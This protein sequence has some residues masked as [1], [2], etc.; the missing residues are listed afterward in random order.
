M[1]WLSRINSPACEMVSLDLGYALQLEI[2]G[3]LRRMSSISAVYAICCPAGI[4]R[5]TTAPLCECNS[6]TSQ[7]PHGKTLRTA[8]GNT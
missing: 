8:Y 5:L 7:G 4:W 3:A 2:C 1:H 6:D